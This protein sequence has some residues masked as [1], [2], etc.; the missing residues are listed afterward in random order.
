M[1]EFHK[2]LVSQILGPKYLDMVVSAIAE[3]MGEIWKE[4][5][6]TKL[7]ASLTKVLEICPLLL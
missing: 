4:R 1:N 6:V 2:L 5:R 3:L 7:A